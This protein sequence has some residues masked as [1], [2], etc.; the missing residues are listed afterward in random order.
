MM[1]RVV[2]GAGANQTNEGP[3]LS[4]VPLFLRSM[5]RNSKHKISFS[6]TGQVPG[7]IIGKPAIR[8]DM[9]PGGEFGRFEFAQ[10]QLG[11]WNTTRL[12]CALI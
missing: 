6:K 10:S 4:R 2:L 7:G 8:L 5:F 11:R 12:K 9:V 3:P 1:Q